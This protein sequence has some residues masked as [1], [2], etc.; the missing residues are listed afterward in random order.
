MRTF[1]KEVGKA[2]SPPSLFKSIKEKLQSIFSI[3]QKKLMP[4]LANQISREDTAFELS[5]KLP[6]LSKKDV[7]IEIEGNT[8]IIGANKVKAEASRYKYG[9]RRK[10]I[11]NSVYRVI[12]IPLDADPDKICAEMK[13]GILK[14][15]IAK[16]ENIKFK[17]ILKVA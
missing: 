15:K 2:K 14:V 7:R 9:V 4:K 13:N 8:M 17:R 11:R 10:L 6:G 16:K 5:M 3:V 1:G 12:E